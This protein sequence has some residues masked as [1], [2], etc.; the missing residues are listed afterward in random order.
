MWDE[1]RITRGDARPLFAQLVVGITHLIAMRPLPEGTPLPSVRSAARIWNVNLHTVRRAYH[2]L[3]ERG[4]VVIRGTRGAFVASAGRAGGQGVAE[5]LRA[6]ADAARERFGLAPD[7]LARALAALEPAGASDA[8]VLECSETLREDLV[9]QLGERWCVR[10]RGWPVERAAQTPSGVVVGTYFHY[11]EVRAA[12]CDR[13]EDVHFVPMRYDAEHVARIAQAASA[14]ELLICNGDPLLT[15][16]I[17][18]EACSALSPGTEVRGIDQR[19]AARQLG[20]AQGP[21]ILFAPGTWDALGPAQREHPRAFPLRIRIV[22]TDLTALGR[23][24]GWRPA[25]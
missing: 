1:I 8:W 14:A 2:E 4:I 10:A 12:L 21:P 13:L 16:V 18:A 11:K 22:E 19:E 20:A 3:A 9:R 7:E 23:A 25:A 17:R 6:T 15:P 5:F 24:A